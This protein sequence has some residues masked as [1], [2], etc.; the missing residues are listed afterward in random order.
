VAVCVCVKAAKEEWL[1][2]QETSCG[3]GLYILSYHKQTA[4]MCFSAH[5]LC[6]ALAPPLQLGFTQLPSAVLRE[7][8]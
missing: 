6:F 7:S 4:H 2:S 3:L 8:R 1:T 5:L